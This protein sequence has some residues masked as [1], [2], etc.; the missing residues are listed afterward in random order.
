MIRHAS[1]CRVLFDAGILENAMQQ[2]RADILLGVNGD[3][4]DSLG[5]RI[6]ELAVTPLTRS[7][8]FEPVLPEQPNQFRPRHSSHVGTER[9]VCQGLN[10]ASLPVRSSATYTRRSGVRD[11]ENT[12]NKKRATVGEYGAERRSRDFRMKVARRTGRFP[13]LVD[14]RSGLNRRLLSFLGEPAVPDWI[15]RASRE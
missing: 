5:F 4:H 6:P 2:A 14:S 10:E 7:Q 9:W 13:Q 8:L 11:T 3:R 1:L 15:D 12:K